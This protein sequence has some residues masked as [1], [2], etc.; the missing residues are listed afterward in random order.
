MVGEWGGDTGSSAFTAALQGGWRL[1]ER[2]ALPNWPDSAHELTVWERGTSPTLFAGDPGG[3]EIEPAQSKFRDHR[4]P[5]KYDSQFKPGNVVVARLLQAPWKHACR[6]CWTVI[7]PVS[8]Q[9]FTK[10]A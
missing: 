10:L 8:T 4:V 3:E 9:S 1:T 2:I 7:S 6:L 5:L